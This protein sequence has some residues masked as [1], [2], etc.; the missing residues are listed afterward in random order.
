MHG[1]NRNN[2]IYDSVLNPDF[3]DRAD[4]LHF[5]GTAI[6]SEQTISYKNIEEVL[7]I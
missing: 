5:N 7:K 3:S 1:K 6:I 4:N 2:D